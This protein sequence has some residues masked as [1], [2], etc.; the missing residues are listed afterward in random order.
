[1]F[2]DRSAVRDAEPWGTHAQYETPIASKSQFGLR[3][4]TR[5][6]API[7]WVRSRYFLIMT[8]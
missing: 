3:L 6:K 2:G 4:A 5:Q 7:G 1:V 8:L